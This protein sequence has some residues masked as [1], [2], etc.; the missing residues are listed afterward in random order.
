MN[1]CDIYRVIV[2]PLRTNCYILKSRT[3]KNALVID[4][5]GDYPLIKEKLDSIQAS[6]RVILLTHGHFDHILATDAL[7]NRLTQVAIYKDD[8]KLLYEKDFFST[9]IENDPRP[10]YPADVVFNKEG[11]Y[12][13]DEFE[14]N[15]LHTPGHTKGSVCY[16]FEDCMFTGDTLFKSSIG[17]TIFGGDDNDFNDSLKRL[18]YYPGD[19]AVLPGH[20]SATTL[21][22]ARVSNPFLMKFKSNGGSI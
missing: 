1:S 2:S 3:S 16:I 14:F 13:I 6:C 12:K 17:T 8:E 10:L 21:S 20:E 15:V 18:Y 4:P 11:K 19:Y 7:R 22:D 9:M 5:G